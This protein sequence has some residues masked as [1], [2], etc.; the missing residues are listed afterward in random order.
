TINEQK[1]KTPSSALTASKILMDEAGI[2]E[3]DSKKFAVNLID[4]KESD[5]SLPSKT[6][7][8]KEREN[9]L[10]RESKEH[11]FNLE[12]TI[13][14]LVFLFMLTEF[15]YIKRRGDL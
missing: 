11:D 12:L 4:E 3:F 6:E 9:L 8:Q 13:L 2:Y 1:V 15:F 5:V 14:G 10:E 7:K